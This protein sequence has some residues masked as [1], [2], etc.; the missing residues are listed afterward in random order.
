MSTQP[1]DAPRPAPSLFDVWAP[2]LPQIA[3]GLLAV[4]GGLALLT[5]VLGYRDNWGNTP[6]VF[7]GVSVGAT[8]VTAGVLALVPDLTYNF[9]PGDFLRLVVLLV[10]SVAGFFTALTGLLLPFVQYRNV[11]G[12]ELKTWREHGGLLGLCI[13]TFVGGLV[14]MF[15]GLSLGRS[16]ER[17]RAVLRRLLYGYNA[18]FS[19]LLV[20]L[21][22]VILNVL[23]YSPV[24]PFSY[25]NGQ[26]IDWTAKHLFSLKPDAKKELASIKEPIKVYIITS[27]RGDMSQDMLTLMRN[28]KEAN[29]LFSFEA[30]SPQLNDEKI[31]ELKKTYRLPE[32]ATGAL[33]VY[34]PE[35]SNKYRLLTRHDL[36]KPYTDSL[37][38]PEMD[39]DSTRTYFVGEIALRKVLRQLA[40]ED[41]P[42]KVYFTQGN[43][44]LNFSQVNRK[45]PFQSMGMLQTGFDEKVFNMAALPFDKDGA[46]KGVPDDAN[47]VVVAGPTE[48]FSKEAVQA[49]RDYLDKRQGK[50]IVLLG[51]VR[52][53]QGE[54][55]RH[56]DLE[57]L[58][59]EHGVA[60]ADDHVLY[61]KYNQIL[62]KARVPDSPDFLFVRANPDTSNPIV[63]TFNDE[64]REFL[65]RQART[66]SKATEAFGGPAR[67][68]VD[69]III[70]PPDRWPFSDP[71]LT[72]SPGK[73]AETVLQ[74]PELR[75]Q[76]V[77]RKPIPLAVAVSED[78]KP[79]LVVAGS[80]A[81][82]SDALILNTVL[83]LNNY[84][85]FNA[86]LAW[87]VDRPD[88]AI[89]ID[90]KPPAY[91]VNIEDRF[92][93]MVLLPGVLMVIGVITFGGGVWVVR[94]R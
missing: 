2:N 44:E 3:Y 71:T 52:N 59:Q 17:S 8:L 73:L 81:W 24:W 78:G 49:L 70:A 38:R 79:R 87:L 60:V 6:L 69:E 62:E 39:E 22:I 29:P 26:P 32:D 50:L 84:E 16:Y 19:T 48:T 77:S 56:T 7:W 47:I 90:E 55:M 27:T 28:C 68:T 61:A 36:Y 65:F 18:V 66:V 91:K 33:V 20:V 76:V 86:S 41:K 89:V 75:N 58:L 5:L 82:V 13:A 53:R 63:T 94:R 64:Q 80:S 1:N 92:L 35:P 72:T 54:G 25:L 40:F 83:G 74:S 45:D 12:T 57:P 15:V 14:L 30:L 93:S 46:A 37:G 23:M 10:L 34:G 42:I 9:T 85:L 67:R 88:L 43:G 21:I 4:G 31:A 51:V 11:L